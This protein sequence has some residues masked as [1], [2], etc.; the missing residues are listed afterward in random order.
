MVDGEIRERLDNISAQMRRDYSE[1]LRELDLH[2]GQDNLLCKLW[3]E[4]GIPQMQLTEY[5]NC[6]PPTTTNMVKT[7]EKKGFVYRKK[8]PADGRVTRIYLTDKGSAVREPIEKVWH[9][10]QDKLLHGLAADERLLLNELLT[11]MEKN[12]I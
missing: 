9:K 2:V 1:M 6:E 5:M 11:K 4:D 3:R 7:L 8:D 10:Q 12:I